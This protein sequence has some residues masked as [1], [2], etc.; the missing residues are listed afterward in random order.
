MKKLSFVLM[1]IAV[2]FQMKTDVYASQNYYSTT[3]L[4]VE[5][6]S[7]AILEQLNA[8][9]PFHPA[10]MTKIMTT[11]VALEMMDESQLQDTY[12]MTHEIFNDLVRMDASVAGFDAGETVRIIDI[13]YGIMLPSGADATRA[14][15]DYI[16]GSEAA[17][18]HLMNKKAHELGLKDTH[19]ENTS[20]LDH[21]N[22][23]TTAHDL[24]IMLEAALKNSTFQKIFAASEYHSAPTNYKESG[25]TWV[26]K[27]LE[28]ANRVDPQNP[29][30]GAKSGYTELAG[31]ALASTASIQGKSYMVISAGAPY[32]PFDFYNVQD[33]LK[34]YAHVPEAST[35]TSKTTPTNVRSE[36]I[37]VKAPDKPAL[38]SSN[39]LFLIGALTTVVGFLM[40]LIRKVFKDS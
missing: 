8:D 11:Y 14:I 35:S 37:V 38:F 5:R 40:Y 15:A 21:P 4:L 16:S 2:F 10:S 7:G 23:L 12:T 34:F 3:Y 29:L 24:R 36:S 17:F 22:H 27:N 25:Y 19:F 13:L 20:G 9:Q 26:D 39:L 30:T 18:V 33:A 28:F 1:I 31:S 32:G 6:E